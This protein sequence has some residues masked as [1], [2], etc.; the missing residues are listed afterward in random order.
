MAA[1]IK[2][3]AAKAGLS[4]AAV[5][6][7]LNGKGDKRFPMATRE[8]VHRAASDIGYRPNAVARSLKSGR[9][10]TI[11]LYTGGG[12]M[13]TSMP[14][15][16][17]IVAGL[18]AGCVQAEQDL[19]MHGRLRRASEV[20]AFA[21]IV[22]GKVDGMILHTALEDDLVERLVAA[23]FPTITIIDRMRSLP[24][25]LVDV[26][27][28]GRLISEHLVGR[29][30]RK[31]IYRMPI[32]PTE[33]IRSRM[34]AFREA[35]EA[36]GLAVTKTI[37]VDWS[38]A[39]TGEETALLTDRSPGRHTA[40]VGCTDVFADPVCD[41]CDELGLRIPD[42][43]AV[44]GFNGVALPTKPLRRLT[45]I[46]APW[47]TMGGLAVALLKEII[48]GREVPAETLIPVELLVGDTT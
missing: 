47:R 31:I 29:G 34:L 23:R 20:D 3:V 22:N 1:S 18:E 4:H 17:E 11:G 8:R 13:D 6:L 28:A 38:G 40:V 37:A 41:A 36:T 35:A 46:R 33:N 12:F 16:A 43:I 9:T 7:I 44:V 26:H 14:F 21:E 24:S 32:D 30:H 39:L 27:T 25:V 19:L 5:S 45:T 42:D 15:F 10:D 48:D 2:D